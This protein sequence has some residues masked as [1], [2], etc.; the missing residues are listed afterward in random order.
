VSSSWHL[1]GGWLVV[2]WVFNVPDV[3]VPHN[4]R[5]QSHWQH[6][7]IFYMTAWRV[8]V[9]LWFLGAFSSTEC[10]VFLFACV[11]LMLLCILAESSQT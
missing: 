7:Y 9:G 11:H 3:Y 8:L 1:Y 4:F 2:S 5:W 6:A 10:S